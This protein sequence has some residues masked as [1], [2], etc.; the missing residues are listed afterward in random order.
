MDVSQEFQTSLQNVGVA[1]L[2]DILKEHGTSVIPTSKIDLVKELSL[3]TINKGIEVFLKRIPAALYKDASTKCKLKSSESLETVAKEK[4]LE[5]L[6]DQVNSSI[7]NDFCNKLGL[8]LEESPTESEIKKSIADEVLL[9]GSEAFFNDLNVTSLKQVCAEYSLRT[10]GSKTELVERLMVK[11]FELEPLEEQEEKENHVNHPRKKKEQKKAS[12]EQI[13]KTKERKE[14]P[15]KKNVKKKEEKKEDK[16]EKTPEKKEDKKESKKRKAEEKSKEERPAKKEKKE[17]KPS[18]SSIHKGTTAFDLH[19]T[20]N[21][22]DL[23][24]YCKS[25]SLAATGSKKDVIKRILEFVDPKHETPHVPIGGIYRGRHL[26]KPR[27]KRDLPPRPP[28]S[29]IKKGASKDELHNK[30]NLTDLQEYCKRN[31]IKSLGT[32]PLLIKR[33]VHYL[34]TGEKK[35]PSE[36]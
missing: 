24:K 18:L 1:V 5:W 32:K 28:I 31:A 21:L 30:F 10:T 9:L 4:G 29:T 11:I 2:K 15:I 19:N 17:T 14:S 13:A 26:K 27:K 36:K 20:H 23:Q 34:D 22:T 6:L 33:I 12:D 8:E 3:L 7:L 25:H 35:L 16:K